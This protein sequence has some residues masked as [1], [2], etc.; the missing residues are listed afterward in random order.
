M[1][2][3]DTQIRLAAVPVERAEAGVSRAIEYLQ[4]HLRLKLY[5]AESDREAYAAARRKLETLK[6]PS[7]R[8]LKN[9]YAWMRFEGTV[10]LRES[11][12]GVTGVVF[13]S[14]EDEANFLLRLDVSVYQTLYGSKPVNQATLD[15]SL[16]RDVIGLCQTLA[17]LFAAD[18]FL[19]STEPD[20]L[21]PVRTGDLTALMN[22][23]DEHLIEES[24]IMLAGLRE[25][26][27]P[28]GA[29]ERAW[30]R[31]NLAVSTSG[32]VVLNLFLPYTADE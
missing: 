6:H 23:Q 25:S 4:E 14:G 32:F 31:E 24:T 17:G 18:G 19:Y 3:F 28:I 1:S 16:A 26:I 29:A 11:R 5:D 30:K 22:G 27:V 2:Y 20:L 7:E 15:E 13:P 10:N 9:H 8:E 21:T 12:H